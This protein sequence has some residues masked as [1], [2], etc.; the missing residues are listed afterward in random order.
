MGEGRGQPLDPSLFETETVD[1]DICVSAN[2]L[3]VR[4]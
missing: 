4:R 2:V 1:L 3:C